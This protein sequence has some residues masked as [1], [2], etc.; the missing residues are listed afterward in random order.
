MRE[1]AVPTHQYKHI[2]EEIEKRKGCA[3][4][5][6]EAM[7]LQ[8]TLRILWFSGILRSSFSVSLIICI[9]WAVTLH[10]ILLV[11]LCLWSRIYDFLPNFPLGWLLFL[12]CFFA[13]DKAEKSLVPKSIFCRLINAI[14]HT[15]IID[16]CLLLCNGF[17]GWW[18]RQKYVGFFV[19]VCVALKND[20]T[21]HLSFLS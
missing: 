2:M 10:N 11:F 14:N 13:D 16:F 1:L 15:S 7:R 6:Q 9:F 17:S 4:R 3:N 21:E 20:L 18:I 8:W 5:K 12:V 19:F